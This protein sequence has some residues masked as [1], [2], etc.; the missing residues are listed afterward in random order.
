MQ[1][2][3]TV[4]GIDPE[5]AEAMLKSRELVPEGRL[6]VTTSPI[7]DVRTQYFGERAYWNED[8]PKMHRTEDITVDGPHGPIPVRFYYPR[9]AKKLPLLLYFH[10]GGFIYGGISSHDKVCR[11]MAGRSGAAFASVDYRLAPEH[12]FPTPLDE[13][14]AVLDYVNAAA[15][16]LGIHA[17]RIGMGGD[18][19]GASITMGTALSL[20]A[21]GRADALKFMLL[22]YG[23]YGLGYDCESSQKYNDV[24][25]GLSETRRKFYRSCYIANE[26]DH[27]DPRLKHLAANVSGLPPAF[28]GAAEMDPL[29]DNTPALSE[30]LTAAGVDNDVKIYPGVLH[31]F[32]HLTRMVS[33]AKEALDDAGDATRAALGA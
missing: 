4:P 31:G 16:A 21:M 1:D 26:T 20:K 32:I 7:A 19:A 29:C 6:D 18:S 22:F 8:G 27:Q 28:L 24:I 14:I 12:K 3:R 9:E 23:S 2:P 11:W 5:M 25:F 15:D 17:D 13:A 33:R 10:G 30:R